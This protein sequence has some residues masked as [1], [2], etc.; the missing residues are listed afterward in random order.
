MQAS[1]KKQKPSAK[2]SQPLTRGDLADVLR[3]LA[4]ELEDAYKAGERPHS[5]DMYDAIETFTAIADRI[6]I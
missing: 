3:E 2:N 1:R 4:I 5:F 6:D